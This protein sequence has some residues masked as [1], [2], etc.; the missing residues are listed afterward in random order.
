[1][2]S[3]INLWVSSMSDIASIMSKLSAHATL[4]GFGG[5]APCLVYG[6]V[7]FFLFCLAIAILASIRAFPRLGAGK[8]KL[9]AGFFIGAGILKSVDGQ[10]RWSV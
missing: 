9:P 3:D 6:N 7:L 8:L 10:C 2:P 1:M 4:P 5:F